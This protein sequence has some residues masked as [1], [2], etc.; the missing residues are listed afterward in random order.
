MDVGKLLHLQRAFQSY[1]EVHSAA[2]K[3]KIR[4]AVE[5]P[6]EIFKLIVLLQDA[7]EL[8]GQCGQSGQELLGLGTGKRSRV[9]AR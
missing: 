8:L 1:W 3:E 5:M 7:L 2:E 4:R 9:C 6:R